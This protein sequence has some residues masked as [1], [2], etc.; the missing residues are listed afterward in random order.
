MGFLSE[1]SRYVKND[2]EVLD[3]VTEQLRKKGKSIVSLNRGDPARY[4]PTPKYI[5]D[6]YVKALMERKTYYSRAQGSVELQTAVSDRYKRMHGL[7][8]DPARIIATAGITEGLSFVNSALI[9]PGEN[10]IIFKP[11]F[12]IY[13]TALELNQGKPIIQRYDENDAWNIHLEELKS[14][15]IRS[16]GRDRLKHVK[17]MMVTNP[18]NP[19]GTVLRRNVLKE[20]VDLANEYGIFLISDEIYDEIVFNGARFTSVSE[21]ARGIPHALLNGVSKSYDS[22]GFRI[23]FIVIPEE[24]RRSDLLR[25]KM[26]EYARARISLNTP[27]EYAVTAALNDPKGHAKALRHRVHEISDRVNFSVKMF[28]E[29]QFLST[30]RPNGAFYVFPKIDL[31]LLKFKTDVQFVTSLLM[32]EGVQV[33]WGS[34]FGEPSHFRI[35]SLAPK[36]ILEHAINKINDFCRKNARR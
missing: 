16:K 6:A 32:E 10:A 26:L 13:T 11:Y 33:V 22:T 27:A 18:N 28:G 15:L 12:T 14:S 20:L 21:L 5:I 8:I 34:A 4:F 2:I 24:D 35:V 9:N 7:D 31:K 29:N 23:G 3:A 17:Y 36:E 25:D 1:R 19:T 30:V